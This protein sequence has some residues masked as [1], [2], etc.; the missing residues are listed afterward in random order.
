MMLLIQTAST[1]PVFE[2]GRL[3]VQNF[4]RNEHN[5]LP[6][7]WDI[8]QDERGV[9][10]IAN[11]QGVL[12]YDGVSWRT[13]YINDDVL[14]HS[15]CVSKTGI[16][17]VGGLDELGCLLPDETG[18]LKYESFIPGIAEENREFEYIWNIIET[19]DGIFFHARTHIFLYRNDS[20]IT[21]DAPKENFYTAFLVNGNFVVYDRYNGLFK[22][23]DDELRLIQGSEKMIDVYSVLPYD[24]DRL[25]IADRDKGLYMIP[26]FSMD[27]RDKIR[28]FRSDINDYL[29]ENNVYNGLIVNDSLFSYG[30]TSG[31]VVIN[32]KGE[33]KYLI[34]NASGIVDESIKAQ[35]SD[36]NGNL[37]L[38]TDNGISRVEINSPV[39]SYD[40]KSGLLGSI[41]S[42]ARANSNL[43]AV[44]GVGV[45]LLKE[46]NSDQILGDRSISDKLFIN[47][48]YREEYW[49]S[50]NFSLNG[51]EQ[52]FALANDSIYQFDRKNRSKTI[53]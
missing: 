14:I 28:Y 46:Y 41:Q 23:V 39:I 31:V 17:Y 9:M 7:I 53:C 34:N 20:I 15:L 52:L 38:G 26:S 13:I 2:S 18:L 29:I 10:Y 47:I 36:K 40:E 21:L 22:Y 50:L 11:N 4:G 24:N 5:G 25:I 45:F 12:E 33:L 6:Q 3:P 37:W 49:A 32:K 19:E 8:V 51:K 42:I 16:V 43:Y 1:Q 30:T 48:G 35:Y 27:I 44:T